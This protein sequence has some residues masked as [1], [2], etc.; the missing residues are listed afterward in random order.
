MQ[1]FENDDHWKALYPFIF[2]EETFISAQ[3]EVDNLLRLAGLSHGRVLDLCC[4]P[5]RHALILAQMGFEVTGVDRSPFLLSRAKE[6]VGSAGQTVEFVEADMREF[7]RPSSFDLVL[8]LYTSFGYLPNPEDDLDLLCT[9][10]RNLRPGGIFVIEVLNKEF[11]LA[12]KQPTLWDEALDGSLSIQH[13]DVLPGCSRIQIQWVLV[14]NDKT[15]RFKYEHNVYS[16]PDLEQMLHVAG[17]DQ[18]RLFGGLQGRPFDP[19][20]ARIIAVA[21][22]ATSTR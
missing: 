4:G 2:E 12:S 11:L 20:A 16:G 13:Y 9:I 6:R 22:R 3:S 17:F 21:Q 10:Q 14:Q 1:W 7:L 5:A 15:S 18:I 19:R 8:N